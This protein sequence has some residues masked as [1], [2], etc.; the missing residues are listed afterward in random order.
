MAFVL[1]E[2][3]HAI[4]GALQR[5]S[6]LT[7]ADLA[8]IIHLSSSQCSRRRM[9]LEKEGIIAGYGA[10]LNLAALGYGLRA[11]TRVNLSAHNEDAAADFERFVTR[12]DEIRAAFSVSGDADYVLSILTRDLAHFAEFIHRQ[13]LP[14]RNVSQVRSE[15]VLKTL[16]DR[17]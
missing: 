1:D 15:I 3:D 7:N 9:R 2:H 10:R 12:H 6:T 17:D 16:K 11:I 14:Q 13:L 4:L 5:D 8:S